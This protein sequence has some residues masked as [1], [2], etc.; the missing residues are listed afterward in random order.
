IEWGI[1]FRRYIAPNQEIDTWTEYS[2]KQGFMIST[3]GTLYGIV[4]KASG[5]YFEIYPE[6]I[7]RYEVISDTTTLKPD[8]SLNVKWDL[9]PQTTVDATINPDFAQ[10]EADP[11]TL[12]LSRYSLRLSER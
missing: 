10:I 7:I 12:N 9:A 2:Q 1:N 4:P 3:F 11:Y 6:G 8:L 5:Y